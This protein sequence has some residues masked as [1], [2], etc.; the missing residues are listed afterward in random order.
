MREHTAVLLHKTKLSF[1]LFMVRYLF[2]LI[3]FLKVG[4]YELL[5]STNHVLRVPLTLKRVKILSSSVPFFYFNSLLDDVLCK[6]AIWADDTARN[7]SCDK[8]SD[9][10]QQVKMSL[11]KPM[12]FNL[13]L[14]I[15][16]CNTR[17]IRKCNCASYYILIFGK[18]FYAC[19]LIHID[20][21]PWI[22]ID[23][24]LLAPWLNN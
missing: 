8:P 11:V 7:W 4:D 19:E 21:K 2:L 10:S 6:I 9:L 16:K 20:L 15:W 17:N 13:I 12:S 23:L 18:L 1:I 3:H 24:F 22:F 5:K 14:E